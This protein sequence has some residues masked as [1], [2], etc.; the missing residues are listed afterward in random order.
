[1][2]KQKSKVKVSTAPLFEVVRVFACK[3]YYNGNLVAT[4]E[5]DTEQGLA[6]KEN[7]FIAKAQLNGALQ[8]GLFK[9]EK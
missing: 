8:L 2:A 4:L 6:A 1:M 3:V 9:G 5:S 7:N